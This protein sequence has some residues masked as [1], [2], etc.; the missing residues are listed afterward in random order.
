MGKHLVASLLLII[1]LFFLPWLWG[2]PSAA[3]PPEPEPD[4]PPAGDTP[5]EEPDPEP[6]PGADQLTPLNVLIAGRLQQ[7]DMQSYLLG[8]VRAEMPASFQEEALKAQAVAARTYILHKIAGGGSANHPE[9]DACDDITC[10]QAYKSEADAA[11]DWGDQAAEYEAR[12]RRAVEETDGECVLYEGA[13][14]LAVFHS[15]SVGT[16]QDAAAVWSA[17]LPYLTA[18]ETPEDAD[19]VPGYYST[20]RFPAAELKERLLAALPDAKLDGP[21]SNWFTDIRQQ[22]NGTVTSLSVGGVAVGG[23]QLRTALDLRSACFTISFEEDEVVFS[24]TG[25]GHG[26]GMSQYGANV[27]AAGG[28]DYREILEWYYTGAHVGT[29][30]E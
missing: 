3:A 23:N 20:A 22:P 8:V 13:P 16:T 1:L 24:V 9:A 4:T 15:S 29:L 30:G 10:C 28:M 17:G 2:E 11:A 14:V 25:Y 21:A 5:L 7:M 26:V 18:V 6:E 19:T 27:L 12:I